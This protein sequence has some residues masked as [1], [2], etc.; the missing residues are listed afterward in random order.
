MW[1]EK[2]HVSVTNITCKISG[3][4]G[5]ANLSIFLFTWRFHEAVILST[6]FFISNLSPYFSLL[7]L[8]FL[9]VVPSPYSPV[10]KLKCGC[11]L[12]IPRGRRIH[13]L[14]MKHSLFHIQRR[15]LYNKVGDNS[16][17]SFQFYANLIHINYRTSSWRQPA[18]NCERTNYETLNF[19]LITRKFSLNSNS[20]NL[21]AHYFISKNPWVRTTVKSLNTA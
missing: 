8:L 2:A 11:M 14:H 1:Y 4:S 9:Y 3:T 18:I 12:F 15:R 13:T 7:S 6:H 20:F 10:R 17:S 16:A 21:L 19:Q 5:G